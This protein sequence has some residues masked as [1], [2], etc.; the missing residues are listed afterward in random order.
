MLS[1]VYRVSY[2]ALIGTSHKLPPTLHRQPLN[3]SWVRA[4]RCKQHLPRY[5]QWSR[6]RYQ[7]AVSTWEKVKKCIQLLWFFFCLEMCCCCSDNCCR[8]LFFS[9]QNANCMLTFGPNTSCMLTIGILMVAN[10]HADHWNPYGSKPCC[11]ISENQHHSYPGPIAS[12]KQAINEAKQLWER[13]SQN[14][15]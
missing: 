15:P 6:T 9:A 2:C 5:P 8:E 4:S 13:S 1:W 10:L 11:M 3:E 7:G 14:L 12:D